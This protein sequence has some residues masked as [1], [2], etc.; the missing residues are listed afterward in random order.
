M[1]F[2]AEWLR[3]QPEID[4]SKIAIMGASY[5]GYMTLMALTK[6]PEVFATG[7][8]LVPVVDWLELYELSDSFFR[9]FVNTLLGGPPSEKE[10]LYRGRSPITHVVNMKAP[11]M[12]MAG[13]KDSRCPIQPIEKFVKNLN[14]MDHPHELAVEEKTGHLSAFM[15][16]EQSIP[17]LTSIL[18]YLK[19]VLP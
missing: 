13:Q 15:K 17:L 19:K 11:V 9:S 1:V 18:N 8:S 16:W 6:K 4:E 10:E 2:G 12:I 7:V 3:A 5:G 14:E